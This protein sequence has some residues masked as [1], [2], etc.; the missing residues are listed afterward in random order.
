MKPYPKINSL[1]NRENGKLKIG[2]FCKKEFELLQD[3]KWTCFEKI[4]GT[5][6][7]VKFQE[8]KVTFGGRTDNAHIPS[9]LLSKLEE[10]FPADKLKSVF[11]ERDVC[12]YGEGFGNKIQ[13]CGKNYISDGVSFALFDILIGKYWLDDS[14]VFDIAENLGIKSVERLT[15]CTI[16]EAENYVRKGFDSVYGIAKAEGMVIRPPVQLFDK[17]GERIIAKIR[18]EDYV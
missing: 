17:H 3:I 16:S 7:R 6:I 14:N 2:E 9:F 5:N 1:Y 13:S 15:T 11:G 18:R 8:G 4:D 12:L 10:L